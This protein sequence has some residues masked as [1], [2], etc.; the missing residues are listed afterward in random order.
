M[1]SLAKLRIAYKIGLG[2]PFGYEKMQHGVAFLIGSAL[3]L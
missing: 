1:V 3:D 2:K